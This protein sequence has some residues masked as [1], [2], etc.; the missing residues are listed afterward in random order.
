VIPIHDHPL[1]AT[2]TVRVQPRA[3]RA[4]IAGRIGEALKISVTAPALQDKANVAVMEFFA[5]IFAVPRTAVQLV[6]GD[7]SRNKVI[8]V[9]G[10][11]ASELEQSLRRH[12]SV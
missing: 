2:F 8:R 10:R 12:F 7:R 3:A 11:T 1:G 9:A 4:A 6:S 5:G